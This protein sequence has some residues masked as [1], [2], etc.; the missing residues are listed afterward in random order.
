MTL[1]RYSCIFTHLSWP[2]GPLVRSAKA[3]ISIRKAGDAYYRDDQVID[4]KLVAALTRALRDFVNRAP[5]LDDL[6]ITPPWLKAN[7]SSAAQKVKENTVN[8]QPIHLADLESMFA[9]PVAMEKIALDLL[10]EPVHRRTADI[11]A[12]AS[13]GYWTAK[14]AAV[15]LVPPGV[16]TV[17]GPLVA[18]SGTVAMT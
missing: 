6:G 13:I 7:A 10:Q 4:A 5:R 8:G 16:V 1:F 9:D 14:L 18:P 15:V 12:F 2:A 3:H 17:I 11:R